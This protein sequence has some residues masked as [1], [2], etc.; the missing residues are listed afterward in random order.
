MIFSLRRW[1][2]ALGGY[3]RPSPPSAQ[4]PVTPADLSAVRTGRFAAAGRGEVEGVVHELLPLDE[5]LLAH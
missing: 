2:G 3:A 5:A 1:Y 4:P